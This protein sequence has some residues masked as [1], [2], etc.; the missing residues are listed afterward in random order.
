MMK[1]RDF[2]FRLLLAAVLPALLL[3][4]AFAVLLT[5]WTRTELE[6]S[7]RQR[8]EAVARQVATASELHLYAGDVAS[9]QASLD[10]LVEAG[11]DI[12]AVAIVDPENRIQASKGA[13]VLPDR[14]P[15]GEAWLR[16]AANDK[17]QLAVPIVVTTLNVEDFG[18]VD[19]LAL[20]PIGHVVVDV[21]LA[22]L[23]RERNHLLGLAVVAF[24]VVALTGGGLAFLLARGVS[25]P[26]AQIISVVE[27]IGRGD[28][29]ARAAISPDCALS[30][31][32]EG[33]NQMAARVAMTQEEM[34]RRIDEA[35][36]ELQQQKR[37]AEQEARVDP[38]TGL[39]N[40]RAFFEMADREVNRAVRHG[41]P[42]ALAM[43][44]M[45]HF[46][47]INDI[48]G[49]AT[50]DRVLV[51]LAEVLRQ[52]TREV[53]VVGRLG[54]EEF[55]ILMPDTSRE[56]AVLA[57]ERLREAVAAISMEMGGHRLFLTASLGVAWLHGSVQQ[58]GD[59]LVQADDA[60]YR[61]KSSGRNRVEIYTGP[62]A[63][64]ARQGNE[65]A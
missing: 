5:Y 13:L 65:M 9:M 21:S 6:S 62:P 38:L 8:I 34:L 14:L 31:L 26:L 16:Q 18:S 47:A 61:A 33:I 39:N 50:G 51:A 19:S 10:A 37:V 64:Q 58:V 12:V 57:A 45:D 32:S 22:T 56:A 54:G 2:R 41:F 15:D 30:S 20:P 3:T 28:L 60:L 1:P 63:G 24:L 53:D 40:R 27:R 23:Q 48:H 7:L 59:L 25:R 36:Q 11:G 55:V 49:H 17:M 29:S 52:S 35:T 42:V 4:T 44:D 46:K 43:L